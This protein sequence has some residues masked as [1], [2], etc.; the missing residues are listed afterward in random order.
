MPFLTANIDRAIVKTQYELRGFL[1]PLGY[2]EE[3][4]SAKS[5]EATTANFIAIAA[6]LGNYSGATDASYVNYD[7]STFEVSFAMC[8]KLANDCDLTING[9]TCNQDNNP[10]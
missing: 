2:R 4:R 5:F 10:P 7:L 3:E 8:K 1:H 6:G 9:I